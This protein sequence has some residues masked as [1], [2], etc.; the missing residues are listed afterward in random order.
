M[1]KLVIGT[2]KTVGVPAIVVEVEKQEKY[3][4]LSR[5]KDDSNNDIGCVVGHRTDE[6]NQK[7]AVVCLNKAY[8]VG[9]SFHWLSSDEAITGLTSYVNMLQFEDPKTATYNCDKILEYAAANGLEAEA[10][11]ECRR[12]SFVI[13]GITYQ[14]QLPTVPELLFIVMN[15]TAINSNDPSVSGQEITSGSSYWSST[16]KSAEQAWKLA[17]SSYG[18]LY[19][20]NK[21][22]TPGR[23]IPILEIPIN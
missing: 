22:T 21:S 9:T 23:A 2:D 1:A 5:V 15:R 18:T 6:N 8:R 7:Y 19:Y 20:L 16:Q 4:L 12:H 17:S 14:G 13:G 3:P 11:T 10:T